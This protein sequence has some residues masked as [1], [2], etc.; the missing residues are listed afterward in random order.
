MRIDNVGNL[1]ASNRLYTSVLQG[2]V[3]VKCPS[4]A[5]AIAAVNALHGRWF[6]GEWISS[7]N[8]CLFLNC[9]NERILILLFFFFLIF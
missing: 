4:I 3:Y 2:N 1:Q 6:A 5:A 9:R 8:I 7:R